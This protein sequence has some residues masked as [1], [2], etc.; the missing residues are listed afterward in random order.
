M[1]NYFILD[2]E[3]F[4]AIVALSGIAVFQPGVAF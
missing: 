2:L 3:S 1:L 4:R